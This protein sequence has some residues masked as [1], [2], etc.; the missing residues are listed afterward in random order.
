[1]RTLR[2]ST[3]VVLCL[4]MLAAAC[5]S[6]SDSKSSATSAATSAPAITDPAP[7]TAH[8]SI[9]EAYVLGAEKGETLQLVDQKDRVIGRG[10]A[11]AFGSLIFRELQPGDGYTVRAVSGK[12][13][14]GTDEFAVL[15]RKN[16]PPESFYKKQKL[17]AGLNYVPM[18]DGI[19]LAMT[20][21]LPAGKTLDDGPFPTLIEYSGYQ[22]AA[23]HDLLNSVV[24]Q[25]TGDKAQAEDPLAPATSTAVGSAIAP[26]LGFAVV[27]VQMRGSGCSGGAFGLFDLP[28]T[29]D[30]YD[31]VETVAA[32]PWVKGNKVG[33]AGISFSGIS[34]L[35][36]GGTQPPHLAAI[37]PMSVT[38]D[39]YT[40]TGYPGGI[41]NSGFALSWI[42]ERADDAKPAPE[43]GQPYARALIKAGDQQCKKNQD[44]RLQTMNVFQVIKDNPYRTPSVFDERS[45]GAWMATIDVPTFLVGQFQDEQ[46][47]GHFPE[48]ISQLADNKNVWITMQ[49]G[50]HVDSLSPSVLT[51]WVEFLELY[52]ADEIPNIPPP[53]LALSG[54]LFKYL[55]DAGSAPVEQS[56]F[57]GTTD[58]AAAKATFEKD[59]RVTILMDN[60]AG[61]QGPG[62]I[63][64]PWQ[65]TFDA[66]PPAQ[67]KATTYYLGADGVLTTTKPDAKSTVTYTADPAARPKQTLPGSGQE[68]AWKAQPPYN[69]TPL[70]AGKGVG[71]TTE[72]LTQDTVIAGPSSMDVYLKSS[73]KDT[74]L[75]VTISEVRPDGQE[76][77][78]QNG[79]LRAS[80]RKLGK[81]ST[82][83][84][85]KPTHLKRDAAPLPKGEYS[86]VR[87]PV[88]PVVH[89]FRAGSRIRVTIEATGGDR[90]RWDFDTVDHGTTQNTI[91]LGGPTPSKFV[92]GVVAG[93]TAKGTPLPAPTALRGEP[94]R[95]YEAAS[96]GG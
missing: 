83:L 1:M 23:P 42:T 15:N 82:A 75:Q 32:Q 34:Q 5:S 56:R 13:V 79:W 65:L 17:A 55:A 39:I 81:D 27:S 66:W 78:V 90:P 86:L 26:L 73:A 35:F 45:P 52:V 59:P 61:P 43:G 64:A 10:K 18:R 44:L 2:R 41:F 95:T 48:S 85:P 54:E 19:E 6:S 77:Y 20:V 60:G 9:D 63:G 51:R 84:D 12:K 38:D 53:V 68:D 87:V 36:A 89:V 49:N 4:A 25:L 40:A 88:F 67:T 28:T 22:V 30:G 14:Y 3:V 58:V 57:A 8:G 11:D 71:F 70:V 29:Y 62:S 33:M 76:T 92:L 93:A 80:H 31:A 94:T 16:Q 47:G 69:W 50:V 74:D 7:F 96:N 91:L 37:A 21:R 72:K 46:T 24:A